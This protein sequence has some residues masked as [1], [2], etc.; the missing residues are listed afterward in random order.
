MSK[1]KKPKRK[2]LKLFSLIKVENLDELKLDY[3]PNYIVLDRL[4]QFADIRFSACLRFGA[5]RA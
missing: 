3:P 1:P 4:L 5:A 2:Y